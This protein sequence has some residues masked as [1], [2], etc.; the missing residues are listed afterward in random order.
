VTIDPLVLDAV[1]LGEWLGLSDRTVRRLDAA[2]KIPRAVW[3]GG[4]KK[5]R[6]DEIRAW[7]A[8]GCPDRAR[9]ERMRQES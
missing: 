7:V 3:I 9:W 2:G 5:W 8:A 1:S 4:S 6:V